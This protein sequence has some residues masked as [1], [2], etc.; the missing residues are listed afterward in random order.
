MTSGLSG[1]TEL[2]IVFGSFALMA[3]V[4]AATAAQ[5]TRRIS[6][7]NFEILGITLGQTD[8]AD[9]ARI[10]GPAQAVQTKDPEEA[11]RCYVSSGADK[12]VLEVQDWVGTVVEFRLFQDPARTL[13]N[14]AATPRVSNLVATGSGL[15]L[16]MSR[17]EVIRLI[18]KPTKDRKEVYIYESSFERPLTV[19][20]E[21]RAKRSYHKPPCLVEVY[22]KIELRFQGPNVVFVDA[23]RSETW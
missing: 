5:K 19:E 16:G 6:P 3:A 13:G 17:G 11:V 2:A 8:E 4:C 21:Q 7:G 22:E 20:E 1:R 10:L 12:T 15:K 23:V 14:C 18:G 9:L